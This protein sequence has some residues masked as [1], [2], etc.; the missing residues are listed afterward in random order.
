MPSKP[1][2]PPPPDPIEITRLIHQAWTRRDYPRAASLATHAAAAL[3]AANPSLARRFATAADIARRYDLVRKEL[4][5]GL[6]TPGC[7]KP[8]LEPRDP[9]SSEARYNM[10]CIPDR[11]ELVGGGV[12]GGRD[13]GEGGDRKDVAEGKMQAG[14]LDG[15]GGCCLPYAL[16][17]GRRKPR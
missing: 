12:G 13:L 17:L 6:V 1:P 15:A 2:P 14:R 4:R 16:V 7:G 11:P 5:A 3:H 9:D 8:V 10:V